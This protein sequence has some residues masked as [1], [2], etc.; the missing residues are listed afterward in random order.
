MKTILA[1][2]L[3]AV[4]IGMAAAPAFAAQ[5]EASAILFGRAYNDGVSAVHVG[6]QSSHYDN[7]PISILYATDNTIG[8]AQA[9]VKGDSH[10]RRAIATRG[11]ALHNIIGIETAA[12]GSSILYYR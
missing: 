12:D 7:L 2:S 10:L 6:P 1:A 11:I 8:R 4:S 5:S 9:Q 3:V